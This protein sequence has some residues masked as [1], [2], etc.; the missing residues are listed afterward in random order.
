MDPH[1]SSDHPLRNT[2]LEADSS[3]EICKTLRG[4]SV[5]FILGYMPH[6]QLI[7][8]TLPNKVCGIKLSSYRVITD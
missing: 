6:N 3:D 8:G 1:R 4:K 7:L 2:S 5:I